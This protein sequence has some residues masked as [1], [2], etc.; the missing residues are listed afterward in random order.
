MAIHF[1]LVACLTFLGMHSRTQPI[2]LRYLFCAWLLLAGQVAA[3]PR[4]AESSWRDDHPRGW[5]GDSEWKQSTWWGTD[6]TC[7]RASFARLFVRPV[8]DLSLVR[9]FTQRSCF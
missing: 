6:L 5:A 8:I 9:S 1:K 4:G 3:M 7:R 2:K